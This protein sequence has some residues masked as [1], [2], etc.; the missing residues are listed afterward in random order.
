MRALKIAL[1]PAGILLMP[2]ILCLGLSA[3]ERVDDEE[4]LQYFVYA[5]W[6]LTAAGTWIIV[7]A[8]SAVILWMINRIP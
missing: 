2:A 5:M 4:S 6:W 8:V 3:A 1:Y 7:V